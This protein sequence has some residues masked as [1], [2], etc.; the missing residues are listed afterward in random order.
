MLQDKKGQ[1]GQR[2]LAV[3]VCKLFNKQTTGSGA[4]KEKTMQN[5]E[6]VEEL[7]KPIIRKFEKEKYTHLL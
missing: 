3:M 5:K 2:G 4:V 1:R 7:E 6:L